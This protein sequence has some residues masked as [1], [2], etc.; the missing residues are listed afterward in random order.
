MCVVYLPDSEVKEHL[1]S[2]L[3]TASVSTVETLL[4]NLY[5]ELCIFFIPSN[6]PPDSDVSDLPLALWQIYSS[7]YKRFYLRFFFYL[8]VE[9]SNYGSISCFSKAIR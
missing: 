3:R 9:C 8:I 1:H 7:R 6:V 2:S 5:E 4:V